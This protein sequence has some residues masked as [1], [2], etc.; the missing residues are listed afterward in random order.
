MHPVDRLSRAAVLLSALAAAA[1]LVLEPGP[2]TAAS[3]LAK[4]LSVSM[5]AVVAARRRAGGLAAALVFS[6]AGDL[7]L[8]WDRHGLFVAGLSAFLLAHLAYIVLF[9]RG[10]RRPA[11]V[12]PARAGAALG[13]F[14][15][16]ASV[17]AWIWTGLGAL[18]VPVTAYMAVLLA[19]AV[20]AQLGRFGTPLV[21]VGAA[22]FVASDSMIG[23]ETF[24]GA[25][26]GSG[27]LIWSTYYLAQ[28]AIT[29]GWLR[30][31]NADDRLAATSR[32]A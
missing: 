12:T 3:L 10:S 9:V 17:A 11:D 24:K 20:V 23:V 13:V 2:T 14:A 22:L 27:P 18:R 5:L 26:A 8:E 1:F 32:R 16:G 29:A 7:L 31:G 19:M 25:F 6:S 21:A 30:H 28:A 4:G 15:G